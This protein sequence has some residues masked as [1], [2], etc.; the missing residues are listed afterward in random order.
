MMEVEFIYKGKNI[1]IP[2]NKNEQMKNICQKFIN[3]EQIDKNLIYYLYNG[4]KINEELTLEKIV[5]DKN[6]NN[7]KILV[8]LVNE[9]DLNKCNLIKSKNI[10]CPEC[11]ENIKL[12]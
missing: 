11:K 6:I 1:N 5:N 8:N 12:K 2:C 9:E 7:I 10:I 4:N 3:K